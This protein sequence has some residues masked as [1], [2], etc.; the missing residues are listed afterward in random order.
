MANIIRQWR[1]H[2]KKPCPAVSFNNVYHAADPT[3]STEIAG[4]NLAYEPRSNH[5]NITCVQNHRLENTSLFTTTIPQ[6]LQRQK[7]TLETVMH[8]PGIEPGASRNC[9]VMDGNG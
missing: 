7:E 5:A 1:E 3:A 4:S 8:R 2:K 6:R 9:P